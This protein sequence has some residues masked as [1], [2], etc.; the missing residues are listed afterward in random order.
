MKGPDESR[1][2]EWRKHPRWYCKKT[3]FTPTGELHEEVISENGIPLLVQELD[4]PPDVSL[5]QKDGTLEYYTYHEYF[6]EASMAHHL[7]G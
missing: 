5:Q 3:I 2:A 7:R 4:K 1:Y 6:D